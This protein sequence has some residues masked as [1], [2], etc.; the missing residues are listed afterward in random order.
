MHCVD[1]VA[2]V[3]PNCAHVNSWQLVTLEPCSNI[4][5]LMETED[6]DSNYHQLVWTTT[7]LH[8]NYKLGIILLF[9]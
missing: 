5:L 4:D 6:D 7:N 9:V 8:L 1:D 3:C 2:R